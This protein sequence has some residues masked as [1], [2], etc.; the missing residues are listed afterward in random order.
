MCFSC[1][2]IL[3]CNT[4]IRVP[5]KRVVERMSSCCFSSEVINCAQVSGIILLL[6]SSLPLMLKCGGNCFLH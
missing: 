5:S 6:L 2:I 3:T 1:Y 4:N